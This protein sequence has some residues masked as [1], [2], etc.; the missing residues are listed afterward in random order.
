MPAPEPPTGLSRRALLIAGTLA[1]AAPLGLVGCA[2]TP[3]AADASPAG[4]TPAAPDAVRFSTTGAVFS[5]VVELTTGSSAE[6]VWQDGSG[7]ELARGTS[8]RIS[9]GSA[10]ARTV[11]MVTE[12]ADVL[13]LNL[14]FGAEDDAGRHSLDA[15]WDK[16]P[17][18]VAEVAG[19][20]LLVNLRRFLAGRTELGG[21]LDFAGLAHLE[22]IECYRAKVE[23]IDLTG[24][25]SLI[26]LCL[27]EN[28]LRGLDLNP[29]A[30]SLRDLRAAGQESGSLEFAPLTEP[31]A[32]LYH[33]CVRDQV[34]TGHPEP[35]MLPVCEEL[36][37]WNCGQS[38]AFPTP[39]YA[40]SVLA[41]DNGYTAADLTGQWTY[42]GGWGTLDL[43]RNRLTAITLTDCRSLQTIR[44][45]D[46]ALDQAA[47]DRVLAEVA[48]WRT[49]GFELVL[50]GSNAAPSEAG[51]RHA[52]ELRGR[53][54]KVSL[55]AS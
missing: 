13:T 36:W 33:F 4:E 27:E 28:R 23:T 8:P 30:G 41:A 39:G 29:V 50:D 5:P 53:K 25:A 7:A 17:E 2:P 15:T 9:F 51:R 22:H 55:A 12:F 10:G 40:H 44:L 48:A 49:P 6:V 47:V 43:T 45:G 42:E 24:C 3:T 52:T 35:A 14:G 21:A 32:Q 26:R 46:N 16:A 54:W 20:P 11:V 31:L 18:A 34:V 19:L 1:A 37:N 38:D